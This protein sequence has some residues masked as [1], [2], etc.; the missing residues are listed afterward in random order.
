MLTDRL[1]DRFH[2]RRESAARPA[3]RARPAF[4]KPGG[5]ARQRLGCFLGCLKSASYFNKL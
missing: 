5:M 2:H 4:K 3:R 1:K